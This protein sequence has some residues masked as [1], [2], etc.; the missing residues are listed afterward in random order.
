MP[1][2]RA[3]PSYRCISELTGDPQAQQSRG[4]A[5]LGGLR[6]RDQPSYNFCVFLKRAETAR[7]AAM[8]CAHVH[9]EQ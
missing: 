2:C 5:L 9:L 7:A 3:K 6:L 4:L 8:P 1:A